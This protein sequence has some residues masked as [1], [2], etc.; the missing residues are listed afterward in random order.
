MIIRTKYL[1]WIQSV[2]DN[3][4]IKIISG[5]RRSGKSVILQ[6]TYEE[7]IDRGVV[8]ENILLI[9]FEA[10]ENQ[11]IRNDND[12][13]EFLKIKSQTSK[14]KIYFLFDE[15]QEVDNWQKV[16]NGLRVSYNCDIYITGS[17]AKL[18]SGELA[19]Y[20]SG[21][22]IELKVY[23][24]SFSEYLTFIDNTNIN[25]DIL[26]YEYL[27]WGGFPVIPS[28]KD[29]EIRKTVLEG[30]FDSILLKDVAL[31]GEIRDKHI[32]TSVTNFLLDNIGQIISS[33]KIADTF[34]SN[35]IKTSASTV[36][37]YLDLLCD[38][39]IFYK[40]SRYDIRGREHLKNMAKYYVIDNGLRNIRLGKTFRDNIG[41]Q[42]ENIV[43]L[44]LN[45]RGFHVSVGKYNAKEIDFVAM[46]SNHIEYIQV[47]YQMPTDSTSEQDNLLHLKDN[48]QKTII[49]ANRMDVGNVDGI[50]VIHVVDWLV[51]N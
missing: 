50:Q 22:Y 28:I 40:V 10:I 41:S 18:L 44:E 33:K 47:T 15:I 6:M 21:R 34:T 35:S 27:N 4:F 3:E 2:I 29:D 17:N 13:I 43:Y 16:I 45:R 51:N 12:L 8:A 9:N 25:L 14:N 39:H 46:K 37:R 1:N 32:L 30:I 49:T 38:A 36:E 23:P 20:L 26:F 31:R 24:L 42:I 5:V 48:Y 7:L 19:T 11:R